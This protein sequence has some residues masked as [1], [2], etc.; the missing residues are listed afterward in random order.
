V[1]VSLASS[2]DEGSIHK[3]PMIEV[4][5]LHKKYGS[6][7]AIEAVN[8]TVQPGEVMGLL[9]VNGAGKT[10]ILRILAGAIGATDGTA[11]IAGYDINR[12]PALARQQVGYLPETIPLYKDMT[13]TDFLDFAA[14]IG[15]VPAK[16][17]P[18]YVARSIERCGLS[19]YRRSLIRKLSQ[20][21]RQRLGIAQAI[22]ANPP[23]IILDEPTR[24]LDPKQILKI[25]Q[26]VGE[27]A[28][29][30]TILMSSHILAEVQASCQRVTIVDRGRIVAVDT[31]QALAELVGSE[32]HYEL[33]SAGEPD[34]VRAVLQDLPGVSSVELRSVA[35][36]KASLLRQTLREQ[37]EKRNLS[38]ITAQTD[39]GPEIVAALVAQGIAVYEIRRSRANLEEVFVALTGAEEKI[40]VGGAS[41]LRQTLCEQNENREI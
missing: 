3:L 14:A 40:G 20:G 30:H 16:K 19:E 38:I 5:N 31:P 24:G 7:T 25:R 8:F 1:W 39:I 6:Q 2:Y 12:Q 18:H 35:V 28:Q 32:Q 37:N 13:V 10:T 36:G 29:D 22:V 9:G 21:Y 33:E 41:L 27:L 11:V 4:T 23:V 26:L 15:Q 17:R 34:Q